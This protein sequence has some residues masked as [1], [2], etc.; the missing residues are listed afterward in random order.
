MS[1]GAASPPQLNLRQNL[2]CDPGFLM[3]LSGGYMFSALL[4]SAVELGIF[5]HLEGSPQTEAELAGRLGGPPEALSRLLVALLSLGLLW[6]DEEGL[7]HNTPLSSQML[8][9]D[10]PVSV[11]AFL[12][13]Q[14]RH[15]YDLFGYL[16]DA[17]LS[18]EPQTHRWRFLEG[19]PA[20]YRETRDPYPKLSQHPEEY[21]LFLEAMNIASFGVGKVIA[22]QVDFQGIRRLL[23]LGGGGGQ[24][25]RELAEAVPHLSVVLVDYPGACNFARELFAQHGL[26]DRAQAVEGD[27]LEKL[28]ET[29]SP[30]DAVH[31]GGILGDWGPEDRLKILKNAREIL[32]PGGKL[33]VGET[34]LNE[35]KDGPILPAL[36]SLSML[37]S[38]QGKNFTPGEVEEMLRAAGFSQIEFFSNRSRGVRDLFVATKE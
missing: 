21:K 17:L 7:Y 9:R 35:E 36:L 25:A 34:L 20:A 37:V 8:T 11:R 13:H 31:L 26:S 12:L 24:I 27:F 33:L 2:Q 3:F 6:R 15:F 38:T 10:G 30:A 28:P 1:Q 32:R 29:L 4:F 23:D 16:T 22:E 18:G 19:T 5:D 14:Q